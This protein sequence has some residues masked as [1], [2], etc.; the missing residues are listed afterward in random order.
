M[1]NCWYL[2]ISYYL[3]FMW[4]NN[5]VSSFNISSW[6]LEKNVER[7]WK[8]FCLWSFMHSEWFTSGTKTIDHQRCKNI[9][10]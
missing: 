5:I 9:E 6:K 10:N 8:H 4:K 7:K 3:L 1:S 2:H